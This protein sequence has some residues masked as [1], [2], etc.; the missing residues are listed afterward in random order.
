MGI[1]GFTK[2]WAESLQFLGPGIP[3]LEVRFEV[4]SDN[5]VETFGGQRSDISVCMIFGCVLIIVYC[6]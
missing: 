3:Y 4:V 5:I 1:S 6:L 2:V